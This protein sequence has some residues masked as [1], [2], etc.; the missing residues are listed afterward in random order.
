MIFVPI[1]SDGWR[2]FGIFAIVSLLLF[3]VSVFLGWIGVL[4]TV[5]C[6]FFFRNPARILPEGEGLIVAPAD[7]QVVNIVT[8]VPPESLEMEGERVRISIF[9]NVFDCHVQR[10]PIKGI[11]K[12][13]LYHQGQFVNASFDKASDLNERN[14]VVLSLEESLEQNQDIAIVQ[15]AGLIARRIRCD[16]KEGDNVKQ[17]DVYGLIR[18]GSR[19]DIY[20]PYGSQSLVQI[21]QTMIGGETVLCRL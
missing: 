20:L 19:V 6:Y 21:G 3:Y 13:V 17:G 18:F 14:T 9:L 15:I 2:F 7:G 12:K 8:I 1:H 10:I 16:I 11:V 5:W 4:L